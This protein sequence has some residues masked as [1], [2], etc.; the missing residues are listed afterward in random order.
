MV[1]SLKFDVLRPQVTFRGCL[2]DD[3]SARRG[4]GGFAAQAR[5]PGCTDMRLNMKNRGLRGFE[6]PQGR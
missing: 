2:H 3:P 1:F 4:G 5:A 6:Q